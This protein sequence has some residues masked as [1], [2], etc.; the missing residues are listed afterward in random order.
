MALAGPRDAVSSRTLSPS[1]RARRGT[2][3]VGLLL[4]ILCFEMGIFLV[5]FPWSS[6]WGSNFFS[7]LTPAWR[8]VW[9]SPY[10]RGAISGLG[11][12]NLYLALLEIFRLQ[13]N[14]QSRDDDSTGAKP[15]PAENS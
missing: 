1:R 11:L 6:Y 3:L 9:I 8:S 2:R 13:F 5:A 7:W 14:Q 12:I 10:F 4:A 15:H